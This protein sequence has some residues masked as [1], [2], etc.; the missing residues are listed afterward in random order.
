MNEQESSMKYLRGIVAV[1]LM[2]SG[3][4]IPTNTVLIAQAQTVE[5]NVSFSWGFGALVGKEKKFV[6]IT[7]DTVLKS[8]DEVKMVIELK[9]ECYVYLIHHSSKGDIA[10][11]FPE[12]VRQFSGDYKTGRNYYVPKGRGW[13]ELDKVTGKESFYLLGSSERLVELEALIGNYHSAKKEDKPAMADGILAEIRNVKRKFRT[14]TTLAERPVTIGGNIRGVE[15]A[16][17]AKRPDVAT[18]VTEIKANN[19]YSKTFTIDH[20]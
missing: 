19:F 20:Q 8:G 9:K 4:G 13:F 6:S 3:L 11:L 7:K 10:L 15:Q 12:D 1:V 2:V 18:I 5:D 14:F 16:E 17:E